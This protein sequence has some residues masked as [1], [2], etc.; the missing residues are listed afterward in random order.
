MKCRICNEP[1]SRESSLK[2]H[3]SRSHVVTI[4][5]PLFKCEECDV[6]F[7]REKQFK[8]HN[9]THLIFKCDDCEN[10]FNTESQLR[11]HSRLHQ[12]F[13]CDKCDKCFN[14][15]Y[16]LKVNL[17]YILVIEYLII[18]PI[19]YYSCMR[20]HTLMIDHLFVQHVILHLKLM[21]IFSLISKFIKM[22]EILYA[23]LVVKCF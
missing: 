20:K 5:T 13:F 18:F 9:Q 7:E 2:Q 6:E 22:K 19:F 12:R 4:K 1:F 10:I 8:Q 16:T 15:K 23:R 3:L 17:N 11:K 14:R 21:L